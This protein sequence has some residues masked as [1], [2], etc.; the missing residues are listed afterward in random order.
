MTT[1][2]NILIDTDSYKP[3]HWKQYPPGTVGMFSYM[4]SRGGKYDRT[5]WFGLQYLMKEY[6]SKP[7]TMEMVEEAREF[8]IGHLGRDDIFNYEGWKYIVEKHDGYLPI[9]ISALPEG[10][11]V[12]TGLPLLTVEST[13][14]KVFWVVSWFETMIMRLWYPTTVA[15]QSFHIKKLIKRYLDETG[16]PLG[17]PFK[18]HDFGS[19]G[20]SSR[21]SAAIGAAAHLVNFKG[22]DT[23]V[24]VLMARDYYREPM[25]GFS[26]P[27]AEHSSI[28]SWTREG[29]LDAYRNMLKQFAKPGAVVAVVS[30][31]Y[32]IFH[33][34]SELWG[35]E[36]R[37]EVVASGATIVIRPD[38]GDPVSVVN[39]LLY[40]LDGRFGSVKNS[41]G[42]KVL[43]RVRLIQG[44]G[45]NEHTIE[46]ILKSAKLAGF[47]ADNISFG[48]GGALLQ[49]VNRDTQRF[50]FKCSAI[51]VDGGEGFEPEWRPVFKDPVTD[52][53]KTSKA[54]RIGTAMT[55]DGKYRVCSY[56][57]CE[58]MLDIVYEN[59]T[60][61]RTESFAH[62]RRR[63]ESAL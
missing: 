42:Y 17:L 57:H 20:V 54:G 38:S 61:Y 26:L 37:D 47:S 39:Q 41:K 31:S 36:L 21:E 52:P 46:A 1:K 6:L 45:I 56:N 32:D 34:A 29:E 18:L 50:A 43:N 5:V 53:G 51:L 7:V 27:A 23:V 14:D 11:V 22:S 13:D 40:I 63:A 3:S 16:D 25:A 33:A 2:D 48:M 62:I 24:G 8:F 15:T 4:E 9:R 35:L 58:N 55:E 28:T 44:D 19:R 60:I 10:S 49:M 30:D 59:G 12:P